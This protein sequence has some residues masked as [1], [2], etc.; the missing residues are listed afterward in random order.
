MDGEADVLEHRIEV[1]AFER[2]GIEAQERVRCRQD[3]EVE[4]GGDPGLHREYGRLEAGGD[5]VAEQRDQGAEQGEDEHPQQHRAFVVPPGAGEL[6]DQRHRR[7]RVLEHVADREIGADVA[8]DERRE[9]KRDEA[10]LNDRHGLGD[11]H[12]RGVAGA[13][14]DERHRRLDER[15]RQR[16]HQRVM[17]DLLD[18]WMRPFLNE[19]PPPERGRVGVGVLGLPTSAAL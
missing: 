18:H 4:G 5:V 2:R 7:V 15:Q 8:R 3:E 12:Q 19:P 14:A 11:R 1:A 9:G 17:A 13:R 10:E 6:V 16:Q